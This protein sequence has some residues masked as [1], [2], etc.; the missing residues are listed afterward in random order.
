VVTSSGSTA[1]DQRAAQVLR[2]LRVK[3]PPNLLIGADVNI[4][5]GPEQ[6][7]QAQNPRTTTP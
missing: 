3:A 2:R 7:L 1:T 6:V 4:A 5:V